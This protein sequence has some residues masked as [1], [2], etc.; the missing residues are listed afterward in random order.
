MTALISKNIVTRKIKT[1]AKMRALKVTRTRNNN[2]QTKYGLAYGN[3]YGTRIEDEEISFA[4]ND[5][6]KIHAVYESEDD[7]DA[8]SPYMVLSESTFFDNG[9][10]VVG[11]TS[12]A[13]G[14]VIQ[15]V[16]TTVTLTKLSV[17]KQRGA[18]ILSKLSTIHGKLQ[19]L[20]LVSSPGGCV[21]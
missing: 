18:Q 1:A 6:Y 9:S 7:N 14:R 17:V 5:V 12:G 20:I 8:E 21:L 19:V 11:K 15:S 16:N 3:L 2:D 13:R 4:L 10:V